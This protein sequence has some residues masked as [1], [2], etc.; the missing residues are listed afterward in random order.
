[1]IK[2]AY[3]TPAT[4]AAKARDILASAGSFRRGGGEVRF[5]PDRAALL[6]LDMQA[7]FLRE[8]SHAFI[9]GAAAI[10]P[11]LKRLTRAFRRLG[12]PVVFTRHTNTPADAGRMSAWWKDLLAPDSPDSEIVPELEAAKAI[13]VE[14]HQY[15]AFHGTELERILR[16]KDV[17]EVV[18]TGLMTHLCCETTARSAFVRG[19]SVFFA[20]DGTATYT[21]AFHRAAVLNLAHGFA[22]PVLVEGILDACLR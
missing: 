8:S 3:F 17:E 14:K 2:E 22:S 12:R 11:G 4:L 21:E 18:V 7:F 16:A 20:V 13:V 6:A 10:L 1:M 19:F 5:R 9:P 15:D